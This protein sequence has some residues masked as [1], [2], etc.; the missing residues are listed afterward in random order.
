MSNNCPNPADC[1][2]PAD[3]D[4]LIHGRLTDPE[5][6]AVTEHL[7]HCTG[8]QQKMDDLAAGGDPRLTDTLR[9]VDRDRPADDAALWKAMS[10]AEADLV[11]TAAQP[12]T[13]DVDEELSL[14]FLQP[15]AE[16]GTLGTLGGFAVLRVVGRGG[17]G[18]VL[19]GR[20][21]YLQR[22]VAVKVID[23]KLADNEVARR[24]FC[25][26]ARAAAAVTHENLVAVHQ[27]DEDEASGLPYLVMQ[28]VHGES[29]DQRLKRAGKMTVPEVARL[30]MQAAAGL[31]AAHAGGLIHRDIKPGNIL[32]EAGT[33][34]V[35]LTDFGL[36][37]AAEDVKLTRTGFVAGSPLYMAPEQARGDELDARSDLFS[38]GS[39]LYEAATGTHPFDGKTP[40]A[41]LRRVADETQTPLHRLDPAIP[42]WLSDVID[43]L[44][45]KEPGDRFQ[46][47]AEVAEIFAAELARSHNLSPLD[48]PAEVCGGTSAYAL[49]PPR[50]HICWKKVAARVVP[51]LLG[52][53]VASLVAAALWPTQTPQPID[54]PPALPAPAP[55]AAAPDRGPPPRFVI[56]GKA[57]P[58]WA[59]SFTPNGET[60][61]T[62]S[63]AGSLQFWAWQ[64]NDRRNALEPERAGNIWAVD[65][66]RDGKYIVAGC[67]NSSALVYDLKTTTRIAL[68]SHPNSVKAAA[69][70]PDGKWLVTGDRGGIIRLWNVPEWVPDP[71][72]LEG[73]D[74]TVHSLAF[75]PDGTILASG[76]S[77]GRVRLWV[78]GEKKARRP[79]VDHAG[80]VYAIAFSPDP[81]TPRL[82][83]AGW[84]GTL[85]VWDPV[86]G[87]KL[88]ALRGHEGDVWAVAFGAGG[89]LLASAG[90]D[91][92]LRIWDVATGKELH[93]YRGTGRGFHVLRWDP[94]GTT[95]AAGSRDGNVYVWDVK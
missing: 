84:D 36:A 1:P 94:T 67:D 29:L 74:G 52:A 61:I 21:P 31:A 80:P 63:E 79:L 20:D 37:R 81:A 27:V 91:G 85:R 71:D 48:V 11:A 64:E 5:S 72:P 17:M 42:Q 9:Q 34:R 78:N 46:T 89:R 88:H 38:L 59:A 76:G 24:R 32:L 8:C 2:P 55:V 95:L 90:S 30:G 51:F 16:P 75:S 87:T 49:R 33:D 3:L 68:L 10:A 92:T 18:V 4:R 25:R 73:Q 45:A 12:R 62:G 54:D 13:T 83:S 6:N 7:G 23:P 53:G 14:D 93:V 41:V 56:D 50:R 35:K 22:D 40:L 86:S 47:A 39:V 19:H 82:A 58:I 57:G 28:L 43:R 65:V 69:F 60:L 70:S 77:D 26:E 44:L 66:S 15:A